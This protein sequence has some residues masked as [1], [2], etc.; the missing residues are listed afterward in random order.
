[1]YLLKL[2]TDSFVISDKT[3]RVCRTFR[4]T[5]AENEE[6]QKETNPS[7]VHVLAVR[8]VETD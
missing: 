8:A 7:S 5:R 4:L 1:M 3:L 2:H 6:K